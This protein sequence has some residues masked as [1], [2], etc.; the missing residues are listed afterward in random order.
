M[1]G[2]FACIQ[3][4]LVAAQITLEAL[5][6]LEYRGYDSWGVA[7]LADQKLSVEKEIGKIGA[8]KLDDQVH[9]L[10]AI[11]HTRWATHGGVTRNNAHPHL[12][13][14]G[15]FAIVHNG[16]VDNFLSLKKELI[17]KGH[18][19]HSQTDTEVIVHLVEEISKEKSFV[20]AVTEAFRRLEGMNACVI[21]DTETHSIIAVKNG[22]PLIVGIG[23]TGEWYLA[24]DAVAIAPHTKTIASMNDNELVHFGP[25]GLTVVDVRD[26]RKKEVVWEQLS[27]DVSAVTVGEYPHFMIKEIGEQPAVAHR[28]LSQVST[29]DIF[30]QISG[31]RCWLVGCGSA[32]FASFFGQYVFTQAG[33]DARYVAGSEFGSQIHLVRNDDVVLFVSQSGE[34]IDLI[35]QAIV[36]QKRRVP[37][38]A[39]VNREGSTLARLSTSV[40]LLQ[41]GPEQCV[42]A[43]KS[44]TAQALVLM[45]LASTNREQTQEQIRKAIARIEKLLTAEYR[46]TVISPIAKTLAQHKNLFVIGR[47]SSYPLALEVALK[48]KEVTY[49][50]AEGI[51]AGELKHGTIALIEPG[52][53]CIVLAP[54]DEHS[55]AI[56]S[57]TM[58]LRARGA[59][60][61]GIAEKNQEYFDAHIEISDCETASG[62]AAVVSMQLVAYEMA[63]LMG[64]DPD[65]PRNL[66]KSV[67]VK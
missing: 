56:L 54:T 15:R 47:G 25:E 59:Y 39:I 8:A 60:V 35:E 36:L 45:Q 63:V 31:K 2:I 33:I 62:I 57:N 4:E 18:R 19:F 3:N 40:V 61:I 9:A 37:I 12:S 14:D 58:E 16:I 49:V 64:R 41:A 13:C 38:L 7:W 28:I 44:F 10:M 21:M 53:P 34:T 1:C 26:G 5:K 50:H 11:G 48:I 42:L 24:S 46:H 6:K 32:G 30:P 66:A 67:T 43:T 23:P 27:Y 65:K 29:L 55:A 20:E 51:A 17:A 22:S 52:T